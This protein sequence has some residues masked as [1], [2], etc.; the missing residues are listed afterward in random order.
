MAGLFYWWMM[1]TVVE[2]LETRLANVAIELAAWEANQVSYSEQGRSVQWTQHYEALLR[3]IETIKKA[4]A[5]Q[6]GPGIVRSYG[7]S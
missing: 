5:M 4:I 7:V 3:S 1:A 6:D 2:N